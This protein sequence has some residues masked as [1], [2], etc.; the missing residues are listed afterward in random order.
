MTAHAM[1]GDR[2]RCLDA[3]M[4]GY[5]AKPVHPDRLFEEIDR[6]MAVRGAAAA[7]AVVVEPVEDAAP[8]LDREV[9]TR[10]VAD[11]AALLAELVGL[12]LD[13][14]PRLLAEIRA[15]AGSGRAGEVEAAAHT[16]KSAAGSMAGV[17]LSAT[18]QAL[19]LIGRRGAL[20]DAAPLIDR[21]ERELARLA[22]ELRRLVPHPQNQPVPNGRSAG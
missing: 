1:E 12:F 3:G 13:E 7:S 4:D 22:A 18:A 10:N 11:D 9:L 8:V 17:Q 16:L 5:V 14:A 6:V 20:A 15:A 19:E 21:L 2:E